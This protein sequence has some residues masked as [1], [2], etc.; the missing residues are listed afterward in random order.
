MNPPILEVFAVM[1]IPNGNSVENTT[2]DK[3]L[4]VKAGTGRV[5]SI[6]P[7]S[8]SNVECDCPAAMC[9]SPAS[10]PGFLQGGTVVLDIVKGVPSSSR[11]ARAR[12]Q[13]PPAS[14]PF[15]SRSVAPFPLSPFPWPLSVHAWLIAWLTGRRRDN[16][17]ESAVDFFRLESGSSARFCP[18]LRV[19]GCPS[20]V[21]RHPA[22][23]LRGFPWNVIGSVFPVSRA[24][25]SVS[26]TTRQ[27]FKKDQPNV[28]GS[29]HSDSYLRIIPLAIPSTSSLFATGAIASKRGKKP[30]P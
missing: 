25:V 27:A 18:W 4:N 12:Y 2:Y 8:R 6:S 15:L 26:V 21:L 9:P 10:P 16:L 29:A 14:P 17:A 19:L 13:R 1:R 30:T 28:P 22:S 20:S 3:G 23:G 24:T 7:F 5:R 11:C